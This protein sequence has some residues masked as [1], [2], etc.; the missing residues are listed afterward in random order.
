M[1]LGTTRKCIECGK[2]HLELFFFQD[3]MCFDCMVKPLFITNTIS[4][5][6]AVGEFCNNCQTK[7]GLE[8]I[9]VDGKLF[10]SRCYTGEM[11]KTQSIK[12][13]CPKCGYHF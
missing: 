4:D 13:D 11:I 3:G 8:R 5:T 9:W 10:C 1:N 2:E 12:K 6:T 7:L